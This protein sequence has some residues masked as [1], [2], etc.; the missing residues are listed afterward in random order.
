MSAMARGKLLPLSSFVRLGWTAGPPQLT[1]Y[2][3]YPSFTINGSSAPGKSSGDA[4]NALEQ[5]TASP[6]AGRGVRMD[7]AIL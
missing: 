3:N 5:I 4:M 2:N 6:A 1:R 7:G